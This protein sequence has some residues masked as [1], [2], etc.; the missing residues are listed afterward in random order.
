MLSEL[1]G[2]ADDEETL[3][4]ALADHGGGGETPREH[5]S[6]HPVDTTIPR[7]IA[8]RGTLPIDLES[9]SLLDVP[10]TI[11]FALGAEIPST[12]E[13]RVLREAFALEPEQ[14]A[15]A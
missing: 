4:V 15:V 12:Y 11:L 3:L 7:I 2:V 1:T 8:G 9:V 5:E 10:P 14:V 6:N 13:G